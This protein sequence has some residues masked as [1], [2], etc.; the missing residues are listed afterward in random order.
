MMAGQWPLTGGLTWRE[1]R[2]MVGR[3]SLALL[4]TTNQVSAN[5]EAQFGHGHMTTGFIE[6]SLFFLNGCMV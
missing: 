2:M 6:V 1:T 4:M 5:A 3:N